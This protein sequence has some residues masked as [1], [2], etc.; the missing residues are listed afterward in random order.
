MRLTRAVSLPLFVGMQMHPAWRQET[1]QPGAPAFEAPDGNFGC[2]AAVERLGLPDA[3][4]QALIDA[5][6]AVLDP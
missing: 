6:F 4:A 1:G 2:F 3:Q 5:G